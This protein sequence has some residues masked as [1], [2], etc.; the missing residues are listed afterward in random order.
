[1]NDNVRVGSTGGHTEATD[2]VAAKPV[3]LSAVAVGF[4]VATVRCA[5]EARLEAQLRKDEVH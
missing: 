5:V 1:M 2:R 3:A 4:D